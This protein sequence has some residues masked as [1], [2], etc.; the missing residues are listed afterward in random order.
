MTVLAW[1]IVTLI[2]TIA[3]ATAAPVFCGPTLLHTMSEPPDIQLTRDYA[4]MRI[5]LYDPHDHFDRVRRLYEGSL[6]ATKSKEQNAWL[7]KASDRVRLFKGAFA[8]EPGFGSLRNE[9]RRL[10]HSHGTAL[11][12]RIDAALVERDRAA[13]ETAF[14]DMF[15]LLIDE[16]LLSIQQ[17]LGDAATVTRVFAHVRRYYAVGVEARLTLKSPAKSRRASVALEGMAQA[18]E[19]FRNG[20]TSDV[21]WFDRERRV[22]VHNIN[23]AIAPPK[24]GGVTFLVI[25]SRIAGHTRRAVVGACI[26]W[27]NILRPELFGQTPVVNTT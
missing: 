7:A 20:A 15:A 19:G 23:L 14:Y 21:G 1:Q 24:L 9:A 25:G 26:A 18:L 6:R 12:S 10:D 27:Q 2:N 17:R 11:A 3:P 16:L 5:L 8:T 22:F 4:A 13:L